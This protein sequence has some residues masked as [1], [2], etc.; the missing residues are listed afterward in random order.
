MR[1]LLTFSLH[2]RTYLYRNGS[3]HMFPNFKVFVDMGLDTD[4]S[5]VVPDDELKKMHFGAML[6]TK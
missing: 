4:M 1:H 6:P 3:L 2:Q 5:R